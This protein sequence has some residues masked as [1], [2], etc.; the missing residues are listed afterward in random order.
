MAN[1]FALFWGWAD[2]E[3]KDWSKA[4]YKRAYARSGEMAKF[5]ASFWGWADYNPKDWS[6]APY[7]R[8]YG[9]E[10]RRSTIVYR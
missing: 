2:Y 1:F 6:S 7:K 5:F 3:P 9:D 10:R 4:A 8:G